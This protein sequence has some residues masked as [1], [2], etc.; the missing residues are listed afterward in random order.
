[1][2]RGR[3]LQRRLSRPVRRAGRNQSACR[4]ARR[5]R[6]ALYNMVPTSDR[7]YYPQYAKCVELDLPVRVYT[8]MNYANDRPYDLG[9][10]KPSRQ[11]GYG[12]PGTAYRCRA[13]RVTVRLHPAQFGPARLRLRHPRIGFVHRG[14]FPH[15]AF[16]NRFFFGFAAP[17]VVVA[18]FP[19]FPFP[20]YL[21]P[22]PKFFVAPPGAT[23]CHALADRP[24][25]R[26]WGS[27]PGA[28]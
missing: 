16:G 24:V 12:L 19:A 11:C 20:Y 4:H 10:P 25:S 6:V 3:R 8:S 7:R 9:A 21:P 28:A 5:G 1:M 14:F 2:R 17:G 23:L 18:P 13:G 27:A 26:N 22:P 15:R